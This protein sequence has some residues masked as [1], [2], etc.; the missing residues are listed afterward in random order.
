MKDK[1]I[2]AEITK[3]WTKTTLAKDLISQRFEGV[4]NVNLER[5]YKLV[6][7][8]LNAHTA[9]G[10]LTETIIAIFEQTI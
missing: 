7:W 5:G 3:N 9:K 10:V 6:D 4:I 2:V 8:R 1:F